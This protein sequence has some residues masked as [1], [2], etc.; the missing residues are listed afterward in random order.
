VQQ[1]GARGAAG[2]REAG[3]AGVGQDF[4][5]GQPGQD[6]IVFVADLDTKAVRRFASRQRLAGKVGGA[7]HGLAL[8]G[9]EVRTFRSFFIPDQGAVLIDVKIEVGHGGLLGPRTD[10]TGNCAK[11]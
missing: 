4:P 1:A 10:E 2:R 3:V 6:A 8:G 11:G 9:I 7:G 5:D